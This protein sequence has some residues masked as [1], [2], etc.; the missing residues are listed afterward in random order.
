MSEQYNFD[1]IRPCRDNEVDKIIAD[2]CQVPYFLGLLG[3]LFPD[4]PR[5]DVLNRLANVHT[6]K[7]FQSQ[8]IIP[9]LNNLVETTSDGLSASGLEA[10][11]PSKAYLFISNHR[12]IILDSAL[13]NV[14]L[15]E[16][17]F[18]TTEIAIGSNLLIYDWIVDLVKLNK[19]FVVKRGLPVRQMMDASATLSAYIRQSITTRH[20][21]IWLAQREGRSKDGN[22][23]T[24]SS[25]LKM[26]NLSGGA[27]AV[28]SFRQ[29]NIVPVAITYECDPCD[30][31][32]AHQ[33]QLRRDFPD[34]QKSK[35]EDLTH[36]STGLLGRKGR[37]HFAFGK[38]INDEL[39]QFTVLNRNAQ[40]T[41]IAEV[42]DRQIHRNYH[43]WPSNYIALDVL[44]NSSRHASE[45]TDTQKVDFFEYI[46]EHIHRLD[47]CDEDFIREQILRSYANPLINQEQAY[48]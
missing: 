5:Q 41:L 1:D 18:D 23:R 22:D 7:E 45:Y 42:I 17:G 20:Q 27:D 29:L 36:M 24:Q 12:D 4:L 38:P 15:D 9:F 31:L 11:D 21:N 6:V 19:S 16:V 25:V 33:A 28:E 37:I 48:K 47:D 13:M 32:K 35:S 39:G 3:K 43:L 14:K 46:N 30:Y 34:Y 2:L 10:L 26:L 44:E 40:I 8:F